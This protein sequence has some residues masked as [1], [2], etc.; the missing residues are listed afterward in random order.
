MLVLQNIQ[1]VKLTKA[2]NIMRKCWYQWPL[3]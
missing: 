2:I 3:V 1:N